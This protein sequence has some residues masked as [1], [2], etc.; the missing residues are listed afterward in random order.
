M[1]SQKSVLVTGAAMGIG[2]GIAERFSEAGYALAAFDI[3]G[4]GA[5]RAT[6]GCP[7]PGAHLLSVSPTQDTRGLRLCYRMC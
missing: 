5:T 7:I 3:D 1:I 2:A 6:A 4:D